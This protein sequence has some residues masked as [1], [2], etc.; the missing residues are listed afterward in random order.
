[1][2]TLSRKWTGANAPR[3]SPEP[4]NCVY[5][6]AVAGLLIALAAFFVSSTYYV[7]YAGLCAGNC[8]TVGSFLTIVLSQPIALAGIVIG[9]A[10]G[11]AYAF[12]TCHRRNRQDAK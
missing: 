8:A 9:A 3:S 4:R 6:G 2:R 1:M 5:R 7:G 11:G 10:I 12:V